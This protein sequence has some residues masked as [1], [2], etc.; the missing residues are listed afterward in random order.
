[1]RI[2]C[3]TEETVEFFYRIGRPDVVVG[4]SVYAVRPENLPNAQTLPRVSAFTHANAKK[5]ADLKPDLII[6]YSDV[7]KEIAKELTDMGLPLLITHQRSIDEIFNSLQM[8]GNLIGEKE[9]TAVFLQEIKNEMQKIVESCPKFDRPM[10]IYFE[11]WDEP[12]IS[13]SLWI[14]ELLELL[15]CESL[16]SQKARSSHKSLSRQVEDREVIDFDPDLIFF[17]WCGKKGDKQSFAR[18]S[19][20]QDIRAVESDMIFEISSDIILQPGLASMIDG[21]R[22]LKGYLVDHFSREKTKNI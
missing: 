21:L 11:E 14:H 15:G 2:V 18:R 17:S 20:Y 13:A 12:R 10:R 4:V 22:L 1:M 5:I 9:K 8:F 19:G 7:Q 6:G 16:G 3:L